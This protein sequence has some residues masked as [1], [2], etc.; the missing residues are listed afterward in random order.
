MI[1]PAP[2]VKFVAESIRMK[3]PVSRF[4]PRRIEEQRAGRR[5]DG[6][7]DLVQREPAVHLRRDRSGVVLIRYIRL[8]LRGRSSIH[9]TSASMR[10][11]T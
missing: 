3:L 1:I 4:C 8:G 11:A 5:D 2:A 9:T 7:A 10:L 6:L